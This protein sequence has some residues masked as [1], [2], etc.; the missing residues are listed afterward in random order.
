MC[1]GI[2]G[3]RKWLLCVVM[4]WSMA[5]SVMSQ[6]Y[7]KLRTFTMA[8]GLGA[9]TISSMVQ[10]EN[11]TMWIATWNG[12]CNYDGYKFR[13]FREPLGKNQQLSTNRINIIEPN[14]RNDLWCITYDSHIYLFDCDT[15][16]FTS[17]DKLIEEYCNVDYKAHNVFSMSNG[18]TWLL[19]KDNISLRANDDSVAIGGGFEVFDANEFGRTS[20]INKVVLDELNQEWL[21]LAGGT[22][23]YSSRL[24]IDYP[25]DFVCNVGGATFLAGPEGDFGKFNSSDGDVTPIVMPADVTYV[26]DMHA[27]GD[28]LVALATNKGSFFYNVQSNTLKPVRTDEVGEWRC[29]AIDVDSRGRVWSFG[30]DG[31]VILTDMRNGESLLLHND[32]D[33]DWLATTSKYQLFHED[34]L[35][36][37]WIVPSQGIFSYYDEETKRLVGYDLNG[38]SERGVNPISNIVKNFRDRQGNLWVTGEHN[39]MLINF[40]KYEFFSTKTVDSQDTRSIMIDDEGSYWVGHYSGHLAIYDKRRHLQGYLTSEGRLSERVA[41]FTDKGIYSIFEDSKGRIWLGT[42]GRGL[43]MLK[44]E[45]EGYAVRRY[46]ADGGEGAITSDNIY[47]VVEDS[48]GNIWIAT[49]GGGVN[50]LRERNVEAGHFEPLTAVAGNAPKDTFQKVRRLT[51]SSEGV[52]VASTTEGLMTFATTIT[53]DTLQRLYFTRRSDNNL[54]SLYASDVT[55]TYISKAGDVY[56]ATMGGGVQRMSADNLL[57]DNLPMEPVEGIDANEGLVL[58]ITEDADGN[59]WFVREGSLNRYN[60][61][62]QGCEVYTSNDWNRTEEFTE[63][64][65]ATNDQR[66]IIAAGTI[67]GFLSFSPTNIHKS[68]YS[69][70]LIFSGVNMQG[71]R[72]I[73]PVIPDRELLIPSDK[74]NTSVYFSAID[75]SGNRDAMRYAYMIKELDNDWSY[76]SD[77]HSVSFNHIPPGHYTLVVRSTNADGVW[78]DNSEELSVY[79]EPTFWESPWAWLIYAVVVTVMVGSVVRIHQLRNRSEIEKK[80]KER[81]LQFFT[82]ISHQL[83]TPLTLI[84]GPINQVLETE[85]LSYKAKQYM[86]FADKN[87]KR[88]LELVDKTIDL[89][90]LEDVNADITTEDLLSDDNSA[91]EA[92]ALSERIDLS[93]LNSRKD[94]IKML[95]IE[96]NEELRFFLSSTLADSYNVIQATNGQEG[97][98]MAMREQPDF[99]IT[100]I[101]MPVM[102]SMSMVRKIKATEDICHIPIIVL[103]A[104]TALS[105]RIEGLNEGVDDY[106]TK[107]FSVA[108]LKSRVSNIIAQRERLQ[109]RYVEQI[110]TSDEKKMLLIDTSEINDT[111]KRFIDNLTKFLEENLSNA[112]LKVDDI[113]RCIGMSRTVFFVKLKSYFGMSPVDFVRKVRLQN[114]EKLI[115]ETSLTFSEVAYR[116]GFSDAKYFGRCFKAETGLTP[117]E[118]RR[119]NK[120]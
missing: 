28:S 67:G 77:A 15:Y 95:V 94:A 113:A 104:R 72:D 48:A 35:Q 43:Y 93:N 20:R 116:V 88:M 85:P 74:R 108:Y 27:L 111:D 62:K 38:G 24:Y 25:F 89:R 101:M 79:I 6:P 26:N 11:G 55:Q 68:N 63:T 60:P 76:T 96:D 115:K 73:R 16:H 54:H 83:R 53:T 51:L 66:T 33:V 65:V 57:A 45:Q 2:R 119:K 106:I 40:N 46:G 4:L 59:L 37:V 39:L 64:L 49:Y 114:A 84:S 92:E 1:V 90:K 103:S 32:T 47:D 98:E 99:I 50:L 58:S 31:T 105:Y 3:I 118:Y 17:V 61:S 41:L 10:A 109:Q 56:V 13:V 71:E 86:E 75:F 82:N 14:S 8:D 29:I 69:P 107:P 87:A 110:N 42:K 30:T 21:F 70:R 91:V 52:M 23:L 19:G 44:K 100:D 5:C 102:D 81:Q 112:D 18:Y 12:L 7:C 117:S 22:Y 78:A 36:T 80:M 9:N 34:E 120:A 97:F